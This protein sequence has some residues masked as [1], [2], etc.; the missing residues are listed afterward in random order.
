MTFDAYCPGHTSYRSVEMI[1]S[2]RNYEFYTITVRYHYLGRYQDRV[3]Q[4]LLSD[5][6]GP[7]RLPKV[8]AHISLPKVPINLSMYPLLLHPRWDNNN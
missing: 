4:R 2:Y 5:R 1:P 6:S 7:Q 8:K 3:T